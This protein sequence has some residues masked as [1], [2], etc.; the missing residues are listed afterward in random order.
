MK[1]VL[2]I[3]LTLL[4]IV[5]GMGF[6]ATSAAMTKSG[7][8]KDFTET[9]VTVLE[10]GK[11]V[12]YKV[13]DGTKVTSNGG[14]AD[15]AGTIN[16]GVVITYKAS[17]G[18]LIQADIPP[19]GLQTQGEIM[20]N[21]QVSQY[22]F[23]TALNLQSVDTRVNTTDSFSIPKD[24]ATTKFS[25]VVVGEEAD[26]GGL[27]RVSDTEYNFPE[28]EIIASSVKVTFDGKAMATP[29]DYKV[30]KEANAAGK[31]VFVKP[32]VAADF[33]KLKV[34]YNKSIREV[35]AK[36]TSNFPYAKHMLI[37]LNGKEIPMVVNG[38]NAFVNT[39]LAGEVVYINSYYKNQPMMF[40]G[41]S[42]TK[43]VVGLLQGDKVAMVE[44]LTLSPEATV[45]NA[46]GDEVAI[47]Q[48]KGNTKILLTT[49]PDY[50]Y[51]VVSVYAQK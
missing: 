14:D 17:K 21:P 5:G 44:R 41:M 18:M 34:E 47:N 1:R 40:Y 2:S 32:I 3:V 33:A 23:L 8:V 11:V 36:E 50:G 7:M 22:G 31:I 19:Y 45:T 37:E 39:N 38:A 10:D 27:V 15:F 35:T 49:D 6:A 43:M 24:S 13:N 12:T 26:E 28:A 51:E 20:A 42:G 25:A 30:T 9:S 46:E 29:A 16:K 48:L 4:L